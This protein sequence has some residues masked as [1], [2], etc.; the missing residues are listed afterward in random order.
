MSIV[1]APLVKRY[2]VT[3]IAPLLPLIRKNISLSLPPPCDS[4]VVVEELNWEHVH[5]ATLP[6]RARLFDF[7][8]SP[9]DLVLCV[10]CIYNS[11]LVP[12]LVS[13][14]NHLTETERTYV[15]VCCEL[16][17]AD[18]LRDVRIFALRCD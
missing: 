9:I 14:L 1:L 5:T 10:D 8:K 16:R 3:D 18:V 11:A 13:T 4:N 15:L 6:S 17:E 7:S 12:P 2:T